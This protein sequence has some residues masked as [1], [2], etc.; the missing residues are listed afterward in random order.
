MTKNTNDPSEQ[1][2][3]ENEQA[4]QDATKSRQRAE[5]EEVAGNHKNDG[6]KDHQG[7]DKGPRGQ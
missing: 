4:Q 5:A 2:Q 7:A 3:R 6:I 1:L